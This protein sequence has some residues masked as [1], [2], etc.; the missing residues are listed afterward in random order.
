M[1]DNLVKGLFF[2]GGFGVIVTYLFLHI[3]GTLTQLANVFPSMTW[4]FWVF[5]MIITTV[6]VLGVYSHFSFKQ[7]MEGWKRDIFVISTCLFLAS[8][9]L[10]SLSVE[11]IRQNKTNTDI[12]RLPL[13]LTALATIG[14]LV[15]VSF[16]TDNWLL[17]AAASIIVFH[18]LF[19]DAM[20]WANLH[21]K[22]KIITV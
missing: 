21:E 11:Y 22:S 15:A 7:R 2:G 8:A 5:S 1:Q 9:M 19:F 12:E 3:T 10:W 6:S 17:I 20:I 13:R 16:S 18:H 14:I 4:K